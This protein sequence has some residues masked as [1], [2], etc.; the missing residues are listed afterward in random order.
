M[1]IVHTA[2]GGYYRRWVNLLA[3]LMLP[4]TA[5][6]LSGRRAEGVGMGLWV[7]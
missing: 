6:F 1:R 4:G 3:T 5:Q 7:S 2:D